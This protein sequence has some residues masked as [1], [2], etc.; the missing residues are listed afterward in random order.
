MK[1]N[2]L[3]RIASVVAAFAFA[4]VMI[5]RSANAS[6]L[7]ILALDRSCDACNFTPIN[8]ADFHTSANFGI[9]HTDLAFHNFDGLNGI[10]HNPF[11]GGDIILNKGLFD[12]PFNDDTWT[13]DGPTPT[14]EPGTLLLLGSGLLS[15]GAVTRKF[16]LVR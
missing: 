2:V 7:Q 13:D 14:P 15:L 10:G 1:G 11:E 4:V 5:P 3:V 9:E 16:I 6:P 12:Q 8:F